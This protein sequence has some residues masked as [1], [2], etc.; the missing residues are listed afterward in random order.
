MRE[1]FFSILDEE[2][3]HWSCG[4]EKTFREGRQAELEVFLGI[5]HR[6][7]GEA[8]DQNWNAYNRKG[9]TMGAA[10][11]MQHGFGTRWTT[12]THQLEQ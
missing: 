3:Q 8:N 2:R 11:A 7:R 1:T 4:T 5:E 12:H 6:L 10:D 9:S